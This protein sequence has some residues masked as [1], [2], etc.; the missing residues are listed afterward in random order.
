M[1][2]L[3]VYVASVNGDADSD[4]C[5]DDN[6]NGIND[7]GDR[8]EPA[9][10]WGLVVDALH[11][12][13]RTNEASDQYYYGMVRPAVPGGILGMGVLNGRGAA[14]KTYLPSLDF[15]LAPWVVTHETAHMLGREHTNT[16]LPLQQGAA[17][18]CWLGQSDEPTWPY[19]DNW[20]Q[21]GA[22]PGVIEI[23]FDVPAQ[24]ALNPSETFDIMGYCMG[25]NWI[26]PHT[27]MGLMDVLAPPPN[28][29]QRTAA[30]PASVGSFWRVSGTIQAGSA[31]VNPIFV[32]ESEGPTQSGSGTYLIEVLGSEANVLSSRRFTPIIPHVSPGLHDP[33]SEGTPF[34]SELVPVHGGAV[35]ILVKD[36]GGET[37]AEIPLGGAP[38]TIS[39]TF[40]A[41][42]EH[43]QGSQTVT[44]TLADADSANHMFQVQYSADAGATWAS[45]AS[46]ETGLSLVV[47]FASLPGSTN[48]SRLRV[49][50]SD[51]VNTGVAISNPFSVAKKAPSANILSPLAG[52][53]F[54]QGTV[55][56]LQAMAFDADD[57]ALTDTSLQ[58]SSDV[59]GLLGSGNDL[60][61]YHL[62]RG[63]HTIMVAAADGDGNIATD[64]VSIFVFDD[65]TA[66]PD[67][68]GDVDLADF[69]NI[70]GCL[71]GP[72]TTPPNPSCR[73]F[74]FDTDGDVDVADFAAFQNC[75]SGKD[76]P[77]GPNCMH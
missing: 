51:G 59:V 25:T 24:K 20:I 5:L 1:A 23:G 58:W 40:P 30:E 2:E 35:R 74:D 70:S 3:E 33:P 16:D 66:D 39:I 37:M 72:R 45:L 11:E 44:W 73:V 41:G 28:A 22:P 15:E 55:V 50:A 9:A 31:T 75:T 19:A 27:A 69:R 18:G 29:A 61:V 46:A 65:P 64:E 32:I 76:T 26:S 56:L 47:D 13:N 62:S 38:P 43:L 54:R 21:S 10:W 34:F 7:L 8:C 48:Q 60:P 68:D 63:R 57:G 12:L 77:A 36:A 71:A 6:A 53:G 42:G 67:F 52:E 14:S 17:A 49:L 4:D